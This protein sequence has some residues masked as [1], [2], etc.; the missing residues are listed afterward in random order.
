MEA[1]CKVV[2]LAEALPEEAWKPLKR[3]PRYEIISRPR[4]KPERIKESIIRFKGYENKRLVG[5][6]IAE[7]E[8]QP[9]KCS[10]A[11]RLIIVRKREEH[12]RA[13]GRAGSL[14]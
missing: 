4:R 3:L 6:D 14:R 9:L 10:R 5:E 11:Y 13:K 8:Y 2:N 1:H 12:Q 7:I